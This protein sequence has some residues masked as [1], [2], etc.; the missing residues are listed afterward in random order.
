MELC[1][2]VALKEAI[3]WARVSR[4]TCSSFNHKLYSFQVAEFRMD[5]QAAAFS[6]N[7]LLESEAHYHYVL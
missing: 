3:C 6:Y 2:H 1:L 4:N 5:S 7:M